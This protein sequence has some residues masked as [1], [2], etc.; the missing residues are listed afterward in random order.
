MFPRE[1]EVGN[2]AKP[3]GGFAERFQLFVRLG[4]EVGGEMAA[5]VSSLGG[6]GASER[7]ARL[8]LT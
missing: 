5:V 4:D 1:E 6:P 7:A 2:D 3:L 8:I